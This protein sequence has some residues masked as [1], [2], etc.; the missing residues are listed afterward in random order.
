M[1]TFAPHHTNDTPGWGSWLNRPLSG[2]WCAL[3]WVVATGFFVGLTWIF[4]GPSVGDGGESM[5]STWA[6]AHGH[7]S[8]AY[9]PGTS[10]QFAGYA[11][12]PRLFIAPL[13]PLLSGGLAALLQIG[14]SVPFPSSHALGPH[15]STG[16]VATYRWALASHSPLPTVRLGYA[17]WLVLMAGAVALLRACGRGRCRW[18]PVALV[19]LACT[20]VVWTPLMEYFH[21]QDIV[22]TGLAL[23]S[24]ACVRRGRWG[25]AGVLLGLALTSQ[26]FA[27]LVIAPLFIVMPAKRRVKFSVATV[28]AAALVVL[29]VLVLT[30]GRALKSVLFGS[31][32]AK[33][34]GGTV[35]W[36]SHVPVTVLTTL[37]RI[38]P[39]LISMLLAWWAVRRIGSRVLEPLPLLS[40][41]ATSLSVRLIV[42]TNFLYYFMALATFL[43]LMDVLR[44]RIRWRLIAWVALVMPAYSH[45]SWGFSLTS[46]PLGLQWRD[47]L[48]MVLLVVALALVLFDVRRG[49]IHWGVVAAIVVVAMG[50]ANL[51]PWTG[52]GFHH[53]LPSWFWQLSLLA[54]GVVMAVEPLM[55]AVFELPA[56]T[57]RGWRGVVFG[58]EGTGAEGRSVSLESLSHESEPLPVG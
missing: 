58:P 37:T 45:S 53:P 38:L 34:I 35:G 25:W 54:A 18:E 24:L 19:L 7:L 33:W 44:S 16:L 39:I 49:R 30:S 41:V 56:E 4:G 14:H 43:I 27:L 9:P 11:A 31:N 46:V 28:A 32:N 40:L 26:Q 6:I 13:W 20:P 21:P 51:P 55:S 10:Y 52:T 1:L 57:T 47:S 48:P 22:A 23:G 15:C 36:E 12:N 3:G 5:Y 42:E 2:S 29:P 17:S 50:I 8:C